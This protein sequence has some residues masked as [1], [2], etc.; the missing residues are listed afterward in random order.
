M[1]RFTALACM[2]ALLAVDVITGRTLITLYIG[3]MKVG[4][5]VLAY[6]SL[7]V[8]RRH[9]GRSVVGLADDAIAIDGENDCSICSIS[10]LLQS[11]V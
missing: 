5:I 8:G 11:I 1:A 7:S 4:M 6:E 3:G 10:F 9:G 2:L